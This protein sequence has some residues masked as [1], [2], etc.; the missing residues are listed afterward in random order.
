MTCITGKTSPVEVLRAADGHQAVRVGQFGEAA[1]L[2]VFLKR[3]S[4]GHDGGGG[5]TCDP[6]TARAG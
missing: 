4:D 5:F 3:S 1:D 2:V 6:G